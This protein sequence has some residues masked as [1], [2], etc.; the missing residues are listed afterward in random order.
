MENPVKEISGVIHLLTQSPP[1]RQRETIQTYFTPNASFTHPFCRTGSWENSRT[2]IQAIYRWYK[3]M[4]PRIE[5]TVNSIAYDEPNLTLYVDISQ[6]FRIYI[7]PFYR[8][9]VRLVTVLKLGRSEGDRKY[10]IESQNDLYQVDQFVKFVAPGSWV[11]V[12]LWQFWATFFCLLGAAAL[13]PVSVVEEL[14]GREGALSNESRDNGLVN[15][16]EI[17]DLEKKARPMVEG[18]II[19]CH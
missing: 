9:P 5:M 19:K 18:I 6:V 14:L 11:L 17:L 1:S 10:Y 12:W 8:A 7:I 15:G 2:L 13:W 3:I 16:I 4:S